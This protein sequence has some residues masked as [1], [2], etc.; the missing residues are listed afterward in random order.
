LEQE[1]AKFYGHTSVHFDSLTKVL[2]LK[3]GVISTLKLDIFNG[4]E[5]VEQDRINILSDALFKDLL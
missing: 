3:N 2:I 4:G 5:M 1:K